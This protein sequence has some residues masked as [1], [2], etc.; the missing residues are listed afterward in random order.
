MTSGPVHRFGDTAQRGNVFDARPGGGVLLGSGNAHT[1]RRCCST[2]AL[3]SS[4]YGDARVRSA[5]ISAGNTEGRSSGGR[6][7]V[8]SALLVDIVFLTA[9][10]RCDDDNDAVN[11]GAG[12]AGIANLD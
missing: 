12:D 7:G 10:T 6:G 3:E 2:V 9:S 4:L 11:E 5:E 1:S 8:R